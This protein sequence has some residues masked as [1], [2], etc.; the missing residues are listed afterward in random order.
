MISMTC[1]E[2]FEDKPGGRLV[3]EVNVGRAD[4]IEA[5][6][7][8]FAFAAAER[9]FHRAA[10]DA[11]APFAQAELDQFAFEAPRPIAS[12]E[13]RGADRGGELEIFPDR[14]VLI[15]SVVLR[16][17][18][19]V[20]LERVEVV[21][22]RLAVEQNLAAGRLQLPAE[23]PHERALAG[24]ARAHHA[25]QLAAIERKA[26]AF[27]PDLAVAEAMVDVDH[28]ETADDVAFFLDDPLGKIAAQ[29][30][31]DIDPDG[32]A[33]RQRSGRAHRD[34]A[35]HDRAVGLEHFEKA[36]ALVVIAGNLE[37]DI[38]AGSGRKQDVVFLEQARVIRDEVFRF[39]GLEL[40]PPAHRARPAPQIEKIQLGVVVKR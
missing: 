7:E 21:V 31:P 12:R 6:V 26:D 24:A 5:D 25:N 27:E 9:L 28:F 33:I 23:H 39:R 38:A 34:V 16:D 13:V 15:E 29:E 22:K 11:V 17:V 20:A 18:T 10:D 35:D 1:S 14:Q 40:K 32:V 2:S 37:Q 30:L 4:H 3:E 8:A 19:D 36:D